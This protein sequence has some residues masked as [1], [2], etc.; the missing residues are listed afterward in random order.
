M[1]R[2]RSP[3][4]RSST[5]LLP[6]QKGCVMNM[7][8]EM[9]FSQRVLATR[10]LD[11]EQLRAASIAGDGDENALAARL[12]REGLLTRF[13]SRQIRAGATNFHVDKYIVVDCLGR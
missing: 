9:T 3:P 4:P 1:N 13:Q 7:Q 11:V 10:L 2:D 8:L 5:S 12:V 6:P